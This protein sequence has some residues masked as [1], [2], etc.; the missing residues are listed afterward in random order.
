MIGL[1]TLLA[2]L[3]VAETRPW[4]HAEV[5]GHASAAAVSGLHPRYPFGV[6]EHPTTGEI[7]ALMTWKDRRMA[8]LCQAGLVEKFVDALAWV[9]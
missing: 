1:A 8:A 9:F 5:K 4:A 7:F 6:S 2:W 3:A